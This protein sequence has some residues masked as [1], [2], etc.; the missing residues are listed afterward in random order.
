M[1]NVLHT[2]AIAEQ[3][4]SPTSILFAHKPK[5]QSRRPA[6]LEEMDKRHPS[7]FQQL[8]KASSCKPTTAQ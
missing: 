6:T 4:V 1:D 5:P 8:E 7:S 2:L 3:L